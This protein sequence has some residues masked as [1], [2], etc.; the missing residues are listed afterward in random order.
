MHGI[1]ERVSLNESSLSSIV[2]NAP[3]DIILKLPESAWNSTSWSFGIVWVASKFWTAM[4]APIV[5]SFS[6]NSGIVQVSIN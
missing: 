3:L 4:T 2:E 5:F 1:V 6:V